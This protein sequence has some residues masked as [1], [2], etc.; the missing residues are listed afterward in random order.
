[1][2]GKFTT[3]S[4]DAALHLALIHI[5]LKETDAAKS[6]LEKVAQQTDVKLA[7]PAAFEAP[8]QLANLLF[9][10]GDNAGALKQYDRA[11]ASTQPGLPA[12]PL[13]AARLNRAWVLR[14]LKDND[15]AADAFASVAKED[16]T[17]RFA[18]EALLERAAILIELGK[19]SDALP[20]LNDLVARFKDAPQAEKALFMKGQ[21]EAHSGQFKEAAESFELY[22][23]KYTT[24]TAREALCGLGESRLQ[25]KESDKAKDA[26]TKALGPKGV[27]ADLDDVTER[28]LLGLAD[29]ALKQSDPA[30]AKR[31]ALRILAE[32]PKSD[33]ADA[34]YLLAGQCSEGL[35]EPEKAIGYYRKLVAERPTSSHVPAA[36]ERLRAL[37]AP[38]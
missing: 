38:K 7:S 24:P 19:H 36:E 27:D 12:E 29:I 13:S 34:A 33:W 14:R 9:D 5:Q 35:K 17:G 21:C 4:L 18:A 30:G 37:G 16:P 11:L 2:D 26:F 1:V 6:L 31:L 20:V 15:K 3:E 32:D 23:Q 28:A 22:A 25:L 8:F 10:G